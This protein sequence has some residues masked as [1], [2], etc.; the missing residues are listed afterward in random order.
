MAEKK[1]NIEKQKLTVSTDRRTDSGTTLF[2]SQFQPTKNFFIV[3]HIP[4][5]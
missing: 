1:Y 2:Q 5:S 4:K 3:S